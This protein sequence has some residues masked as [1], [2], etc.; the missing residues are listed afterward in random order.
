M[1]KLHLMLGTS[2]FALALVL[3]GCA[4]NGP[5]DTRTS[6]SS[7]PRSNATKADE[8]FVTMMIPHHQQAIEMSDIVI[9]KDDVDPEVT[10]LAQKIKKAQAP[11]IDRML[12]WLE[13]WGIEYD[14]DSGSM[15][16]TD[17]GS[18]NGMMSGDDIRELTKA[19]G[20]TASRLYLEQMIQH[21]EGAVDMAETALK[22]AKNPDVRELAQQVIDDQN[23]EILTMRELIATL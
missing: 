21:H 19:D 4:T 18:M 1:K 16:G 9:S 10:E 8:M 17:H 23:A 6:T 13:E 15:N 5:S 3:T 11:E 7:T 12:G 20:P 14:P 2:A 22:E